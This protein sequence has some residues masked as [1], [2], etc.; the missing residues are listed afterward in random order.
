L[1]AA[2]YHEWRPTPATYLCAGEPV[3]VF[4]PRMVALKAFLEAR[5]EKC[6]A[7]VSHWGVIRSLTK[8]DPRNCELNI[9]SIDALQKEPF[10]DNY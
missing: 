7:I 5:E 3:D 6:I 1:D 4:K 10:V 9:I 2:D 8:L